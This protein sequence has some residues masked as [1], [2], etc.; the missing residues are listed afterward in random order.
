MQWIPGSGPWNDDFIVAGEG[1]YGFPGRGPGMTIDFVLAGVLSGLQELGLAMTIN[2]SPCHFG[3]GTVRTRDLERTT[4][5]GTHPLHVIPAK[6][7]MR[8]DPESF[9]PS[10]RA[11]QHSTGVYTGAVSSRTPTVYKTIIDVPKNPGPGP[12]LSAG[13]TRSL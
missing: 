5:N 13:A 3:H 7:P 6:E 11:T 8:R 4:R 12:L 10:F 1:V 2:K 9:L